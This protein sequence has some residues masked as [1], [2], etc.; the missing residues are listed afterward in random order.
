MS[1]ILECFQHI[2]KCNHFG[3]TLLLSFFHKMG[4][5]HY[6]LYLP[7]R[8]QVCF[9]FPLLDLIITWLIMFTV[10]PS[11]DVIGR[12]NYEIKITYMRYHIL[13]IQHLRVA[14]ILLCTLNTYGSSY[15]KLHHSGVS[16]VSFRHPKWNVHSTIST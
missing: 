1:L 12:S 7:L 16:F 5:F 15:Y 8:F 13:L 3:Q 4:F 11:L 10:K 6:L 14:L 9:R 2:R